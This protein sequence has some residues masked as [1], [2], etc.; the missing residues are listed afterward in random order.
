MRRVFILGLGLF[1]AACG[2]SGDKPK[3]QPMT[4]NSRL[5]YHGGAFGV[6]TMC[7][8][9]NRVYMTETGLFQVVPGGCPDGQP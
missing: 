9:G 2:G 6:Y 4:P 1:L 3:L 5:I 8:R 7:D